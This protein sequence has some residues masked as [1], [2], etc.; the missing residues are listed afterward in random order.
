MSDSLRLRG[1]WPTRLLHPWD[2]PGKSTG[3]GCH[4]L[5]Q[6]IFLTLGSNPGL[7]HCRQTL[8]CLSHQGSPNR[9]APGTP[10]QV[11]AL[12]PCSCLSSVR[13]SRGFWVSLFVSHHLSACLLA[14][15][16]LSDLRYHHFH[17][18][19]SFPDNKTC[20]TP[21]VISKPPCTQHRWMLIKRNAHR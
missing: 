9:E 15:A 16:V 3:V 18:C 13:L 19:A 12:L 1:L 6:G 8:Y 17:L 14:I 11:P 20:P 4:L 21:R 10:T 5:L 2:I 7:P